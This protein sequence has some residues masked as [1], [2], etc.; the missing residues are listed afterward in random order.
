M[1]HLIP[2]FISLQIFVSCTKQKEVKPP[3]NLSY[4]QAGQLQDKGQ[5]DSAFQAYNKAKEIFLSHK[6]N[7][8]AAKCL[9]NMG[10][11]SSNKSDYYGAQEIS[12]SAIGLLQSS[13][14]S[15]QDYIRS[16]YNNLGIATHNLEDY[17]SAL[18]FFNLALQF[19]KDTFNNNI[20]RNNMAKSY[21]MIGQY[22]AALKLYSQVLKGNKRN[23]KEYARTITN[24]SYI[25]WLQ[26]NHYNPV[27]NYLK[28]LH[29]R[30]KNQDLWGQNSSFYHLSD[31]YNERKPDS[32]YFY[33]T[34][35]FVIASK[36][37]SLDNQV[38]ALRR[39]M[40]SSTGKALKG[41]F[42]SFDLFNDSLQAQRKKSKNQ[43]ALI[44]YETERRKAELL[45]SQAENIQRKTDLSRRNIILCFLLLSILFLVWWYQKRKFSLRQQTELE[46]KKT[47]LNYVKKIHDRVANKV[48][49]VMSEVENSTILE[50][51]RIVDQLEGLYYITRDISYERSDLS[52]GLNF[53]Q[54][55]HQMVKSYESH[56]VGITT[57]GNEEE[58][59]SQV[60]FGVKTELYYIIQELLTNMR[61]HSKANFVVLKFKQ[62]QRQISI[63]YIDN[64][65]GMK[66]F[67]KKNGL[68]NTENRIKLI[69][70]SIIFDSSQQEEFKIVIVFPIA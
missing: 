34:Q 9:V 1:K 43:F 66:H 39:L 10:I 67:N 59:W 47:E 60:S 23:D 20:I 41:Y 52:P 64:G 35:M 28:S 46:I 63:T 31:Y 26:N 55:L 8:G 21:E 15:H 13:D 65:I 53:I 37:K 27:P 54:Q 57:V 69:S 44:R 29:I 22:N 32:A 45:I 18:R 42:K 61:K 49:Q 14:I 50:R 36:L 4:E 58:L 7:F 56:E 6:N 3:A 30:Q 40:R 17:Q 25:R 51:E 24:I 16:N 12:L 33:A 70:G 38:E 2:F 62:M 5:E 11:I 19:S 68:N 48:Y